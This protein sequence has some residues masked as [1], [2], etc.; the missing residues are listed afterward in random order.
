M[1]KQTKYK[2][3]AV[4][5]GPV[6][7]DIKATAEKVCGFIAEAAAN[8]AKLV[9][10]PEALLPGYPWWVWL[11]D[12]TSYEPYFRRLLENAVYI[13]DEHMAKISQCAKE[14]GIYVCVSG[15]ER[16]GDSVYMTQFWFDDEGNLIGKHRKMKA[17]A[18]ERRAWRD[19]DGSTCV[20]YDTPL[21]RLG[22]LMCAEHHVPAYRAIVGS[23]S[24]QVHVAGYP[25]LP[26]ELPG[27][28]GLNGPLNAVRTLCIEN[29]AYALMSTQVMN[30]DAIE[31]L[32]GD[33]E[34]L[35]NKMPTTIQGF[36]GPGGGFAAVIDPFGNIISGEPLD[37]REEGI[38]YAQ[39]DLNK[40][41][42]G[43]M[44]YGTYENACT[45]GY[46]HLV[47]D[48]KPEKP[49]I[50]KYPQVDNSVSYDDIQSRNY[51]KNNANS[52]II[53]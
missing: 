39:I 2:V 29:K 5:T 9:S 47:L 30:M 25:P 15:H 43:K 42:L 4:Q 46:M 17:T 8:G 22:S 3:A 24:E 23:Q 45:G 49:L 21:G 33:D 18:A 10:F 31:M 19:G 20:V 13:G 28:M 12:D 34:N 44:M 32:C 7:L 40:C 35:I 14:N 27:T 36:G 38:V 41:I 6:Y 11:G 50:R 26:I 1:N 51:L 16:C 37:P 52:T 48:N 53:G